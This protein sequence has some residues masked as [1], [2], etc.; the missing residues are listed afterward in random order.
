M[1]KMFPNLLLLALALAFLASPS[2]SFAA[3]A[4]PAG[5]V[6]AQGGGLLLD[7]APFT[8]KGVD[9]FPRDYA[10]TSMADWDWNA[11]DLE[12]SLAESLHAN[13][14]RISIQYPYSTGNPDRQ[15]NVLA[16][17]IV[18]LAYIGAM[19]HF[20]TLADKHHLKTIFALND[21]VWTDLWQPQN[22]AVEQDYLASLAPHFA[23]DPRL[24][25][26]DIAPGLDSAMLLPPPAGSYGTI[27]WSTRENLLAF[28]KMVSTEMRQ[29]DPNHLLAA[30]VSWPSTAVLLQDDVDI[31]F[32]QL[33]GVDYPGVLAGPSAGTAEDYAHW[34][35][36]VAQP[37]ASFTALQA[38][39]QS[40]QSQ[41][42]HPMPLAISAFGL[43]TY[44]PSGSTPAQQAAVYQ[45]VSRLAFTSPRPA[46]AGLR[47]AG[48][49]AWTLVDF[50]WP[51][52]AAIPTDA[53]G[54]SN[55]R[56]A[57]AST[58]IN[59]EL[60]FGLYTTTYQPKPAAAVLG[61]F[62]NPEQ[63]L[64]LQPP[65]SQSPAGS[66][67]LTVS[68]SFSIPI[69]D[70]AV[71]VQVSP[72]LSGWTDAATL[73]STP[74]S[75]SVTPSG[76]SFSAAVPLRRGQ[77]G[78]VR[79]VWAGDGLY[80]PVASEPVPF[81]FNLVKSS[82]SLTPLPAMIL[83]GDDLTISGR[84]V[85]ADSGLSLSLTLTA[86]GG[87]TQTQP[88][89]TGPGGAFSAEYRPAQAGHWVVSF[90][91][92]GN[93]DYATLEQSAAFDVAQPA[94]D[95]S[96]STDSASPGDTVLLSGF[97]TPSLKDEPI[98]LSLNL[99]DGALQNDS[100]QTAADGS[101]TYTIVP[102]ASGAWSVS[103]APP[104]IASPYSTT[105]SGLTFNVQASIQPYLY[106]GLALVGVVV[107]GTL[108][109]SIVALRKKKSSL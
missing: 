95:C 89:L 42:A 55:D 102:E 34:D 66:E 4:P 43:T 74:G 54:F 24:A 22:F 105:C 32:P 41:L 108:A 69:S 88:V 109:G 31:L 101:F 40:I 27:P 39:I 7:G 62:F 99:P 92:E 96:L 26:W 104:G 20:L 86:P 76:G 9:Y 98:S 12:L 28:V 37:D 83:Q 60:N 90:R 61:N 82:L 52:S 36:I 75:S 57:D 64:T 107:A 14:V 94:L 58:D 3:P 25:A 106:I 59:P 63:T 1:P 33:F 6:T 80:L 46:G 81:Q 85:P 8:I 97:L 29:L 47:L 5:F 87:S 16:T 44:Q 93:A 71:T 18:T 72:S 38:K 21:G 78:F 70:G 67:T 49:L 68:G 10:F 100:V 56:Q 2:P 48:V 79:A 51:P 103:A 84:M 30:G 77:G 45:A 11:V 19:D 17:R 91:W 13:T 23:A 50:T 15:K 35:T 65:S 53:S 73:T